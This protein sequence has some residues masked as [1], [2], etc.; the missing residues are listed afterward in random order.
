MRRLMKH[1]YHFDQEEEPVVFL[2]R[3]IVDGPNITSV[4][5]LMVPE[6]G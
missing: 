6:E 5:L 2:A 4:G 3:V 1:P